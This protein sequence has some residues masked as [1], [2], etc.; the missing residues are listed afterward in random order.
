MPSWQSYLVKPAARLLRLARFLPLVSSSTLR[1]IFLIPYLN[2]FIPLILYT[3]LL[4]SA[5]I[6]VEILL[7]QL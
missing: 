7:Q 6:A 1:E 3:F 5:K 2:H 4:T